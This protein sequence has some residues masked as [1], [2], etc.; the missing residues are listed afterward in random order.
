MRLYSDTAHSYA[1]ISFTFSRHRMIERAADMAERPFYGPLDVPQ[2]V[3]W[4]TPQAHFVKNHPMRL[5]LW[6]KRPLA[7]APHA[8][9]AFAA[10]AAR[11]FA[12]LAA[13]FA[14]AS[15]EIVRFFRAAFLAR[16]PSRIAVPVSAIPLYA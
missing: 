2:Q 1:L 15:G 8:P 3:L 5:G 6:M 12:R 7:S 13:S 11:A 16:V 4:V 9:F 10:L 14:L